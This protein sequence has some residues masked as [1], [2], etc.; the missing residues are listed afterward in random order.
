MKPE[1]LSPDQPFCPPDCPFLSARAFLPNTLPFYCKR[2]ET[3]LTTHEKNVNRCDQCLGEVKSITEKGVKFI[4][5]MGG[6]D[7]L[8][9]HFKSLNKM[10]QKMFV[11]LMMKTGTTVI[12]GAYQNR[13]KNELMD[14]IMMSWDRHSRIAGAPETK[15]FKALIDK[16]CKTTPECLTK[17]NQTLLLNLFMV[18]DASEKQ[19]MN[20]ILQ[21]PGQTKAFL[22]Q[23]NH[24]PKDYNLLKDTRRILYEIDEIMHQH[25]SQHANH[26]SKEE[27]VHQSQLARPTLTR[28][29]Y[30][31]LEQENINRMDQMNRVRVQNRKSERTKKQSKRLEQEV[32]HRRHNKGRELV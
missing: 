20:N 17:D 28:K 8:V 3:Y 25:E 21:S 18:M 12:I 32:L 6:N 16:T 11:D 1:D 19:I 4:R 29:Q 15:A 9:A 2:Y 30:Q 7:A 13:T 22:D 31:R 23:F 5:D 26:L 27:Q 24:Q 14:N 10:M